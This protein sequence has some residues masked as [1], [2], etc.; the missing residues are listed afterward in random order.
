MNLRLFSIWGVLLTGFALGLISSCTVQDAELPRQQHITVYTETIGRY[1]SL[2]YKKFEKEE[3]IHVRVRQLD[4]SEILQ[5]IKTERYNCEADLILLNDYE[6]LSKA[7]KEDLFRP[8][9]SELLLQNIDPIYRSGQRKWFALSKTPIVLVYHKDR[10]KRDTIKNYYDLISAKWKGKLA[11]QAVDDPTLHSFRRTVRLI[12]KERA[13]SFLLKLSRQSVLPLMGNDIDQIERIRRGDALFAL[14]KLSS[15]AKQHQLAYAGKNKTLVVQPI[16]PNQRKK[17]CY[18]T[19]SG[20]GV[21]KYSA[22]PGSAIKLLEFLSSKRAQY[23]YAAGRMHTPLIQG[24]KSDVLLDS[25]GKYRG[26][27]YRKRFKKG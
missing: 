1:D 21:Y 19:I 17:G 22:N 25:Y 11:F 2:I 26:R 4:R 3:H 24:I 12:M 16:F 18:I 20:G 14:V 27:F 8:V 9:K 15:L 23:Y 5:R 7:V 13:D 6:L 10:I